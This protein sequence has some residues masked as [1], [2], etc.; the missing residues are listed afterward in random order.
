MIEKGFKKIGFIGLGVMGSRMCERLLL[1]ENDLFVN[2]ISE[3]AMLRLVDKGAIRAVSPEAL[4]E[5]CDIILTSLP[6]SAIVENVVFGESGLLGGVREGAIL[7]EL[8][9]STPSTTERVGSALQKKGAYMIDAPVSRGA[10]AA[11]NGTLSIMVGGDV[12][13]ID[14]CR[15]ILDQLGTDILHTGK[16][17]TGHAMKALNN[18][19]NATNLIAACE[20]LVIAHKEGVKPENFTEAINNSSG[21]SHITT[22]RFPKYFLNR[23]FNSNFTLGLMYKDC[24]IALEMAQKMGTPMLFTSLTQQVYAMGMSK[25]MANEDNTRIL[26]VIEDVLG[27]SVK[28]EVEMDSVS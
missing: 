5:Q 18:L 1:L 17:G 24:S 19:L 15:F 21:A 23:A 10:G 20:G 14:S 3:E 4:A 27:H 2:D 22:V 11:A 6:N 13:V 28:E 9:S 7:I 12:E 25:G 8:S 26:E 16:L